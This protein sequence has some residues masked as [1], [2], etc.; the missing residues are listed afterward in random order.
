MLYASLSIIL[1]FV[2]GAFPAAQ[3]DAPPRSGP[4]LVEN[5]QQYRVGEFPSRWR[6]I[7][8]RDRAETLD[9]LVASN[10]SFQVQQE[11]GRKFLRLTTEAR[12]LRI[13]LRTGVDFT[14]DLEEHPLISWDWRAIELPR[15]A[16]EDRVN[17]TGAAFYVTFGPDWLGR[18]RSIKYTYSSQLPKGTVVRFGSLRVLVVDTGAE[19]IGD[20]RSVERD[21]IADYRSIFGG[22]PPGNPVAIT[23]WSDSDQTQTSSKADFDNIRLLPPRSR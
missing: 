15:G 10:R 1:L 6:F 7:A 3:A 17:D 20:W 23:L 5:F 4:V 8:G 12:S 21:V 19:G 11:R 18:P 22:D 13:S 2:L 9:V 14:W 16:R